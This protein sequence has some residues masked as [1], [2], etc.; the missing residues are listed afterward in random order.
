MDECN[1]VMSTA[2]SKSA[3]LD[4]NDIVHAVLFYSPYSHVFLSHMHALIYVASRQL[5]VPAT[6]S[7]LICYHTYD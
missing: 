2:L 4:S 5:H 1:S 3:A 6:A 7:S